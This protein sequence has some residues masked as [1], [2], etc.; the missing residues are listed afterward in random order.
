MGR[1]AANRL[2]TNLVITSAGWSVP[3]TLFA[4]IS[5]KLVFSCNY[6]FGVSK[7]SKRPKPKCDDR[8]SYRT[9]GQ[10]DYL[11]HNFTQLRQQLRR[12]RHLDFARDR[13]LDVD[14]R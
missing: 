11:R 12:I 5:P 7:C 10:Q 13:R 6:Q 1:I 3:K 2:S 14:L 9:T 4:L 8:L